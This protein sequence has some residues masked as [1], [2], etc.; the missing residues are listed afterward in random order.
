MNSKFPIEFDLLVLGELIECGDDFIIVDWFGG[1]QLKIKKSILVGDWD[2]VKVGDWLRAKIFYRVH[3]W[4]APDKIYSAEFL[5]KDEPP[6]TMTQEEIDLFY[7]RLMPAELT[8]ID[9]N[10]S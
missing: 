6:K 2:S 4:E 3:S 5:G 9:W 10:E 8:P 1:D 7:S